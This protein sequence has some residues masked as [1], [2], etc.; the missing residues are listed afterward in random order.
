M[1]NKNGKLDV[2]EIKIFY[3]VKENKNEQISYKLGKIS[4]KRLYD[5]GLVSKIYRVL[6]T[7]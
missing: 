6:K 5:Q 2:I 3:A 7:Q 4:I 1:I